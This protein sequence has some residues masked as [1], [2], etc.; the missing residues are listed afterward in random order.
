MTEDITN[1]LTVA[2]QLAPLEGLPFS[3][4]L[5]GSK[6]VGKSTLL[7]Y[8]V[9]KFLNKYSE[10][11]RVA[12]VQVDLSPFPFHAD[13]RPLPTWTW[14]LAK[15]SLPRPGRWPC[16]WSKTRSWDRP[17]RMSG[18][19]T[20]LSSSDACRQGTVRLSMWKPVGLCIEPT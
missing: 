10:P 8:L 19:R 1:E 20:S 9:N 13:T 15:V 18:I 17:A 11:H 7:R 4:V 12:I 14:I 5:L 2:S 16:N 6:G 3:C